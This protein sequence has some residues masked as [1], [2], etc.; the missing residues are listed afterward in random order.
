VDVTTAEP[1]A[2]AEGLAEALGWS[3][4]PLDTV[5]GI[6]R[7]G[8]SDEYLDVAGLRGAT[9]EEDLRGRDFTINAMAIRLPEGDGQAEFLDPT[10]GVDDL[11]A[12][13]LRMASPTAFRDDPVRVMRGFR[14][15]AT[16]GHT[17]EPATLTALQ[18][19]VPRLTRPAPERIQAEWRHVCASSRAYTVVRDMD[20]A[21]ALDVLFPE[22]Q[23]C[24]GVTQNAYHAYDVFEHQ[25]HALE[26]M[27]ALL[28]DP[29]GVLG[30]VADRLL[31]DPDDEFVRGRLCFAALVHDIGKP[32]ARTRDA[33]GVHFHGHELKGAEM[34]RTI[35]ERMRVLLLIRVPMVEAIRNH[36]RPTQLLRAGASPRAMLKFVEATRGMMEDVLLLALADKSA[37]P[38]PA[39]D[40]EIVPKLVALSATLLDFRAEQYVPAI[41]HPLLTGDDLLAA[42]IPQGPRVG[43]LLAEVRR[44][45]VLGELRTREQAER[46][47]GRMRNAE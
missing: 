45:Q 46:W 47:M 22:L 39:A 30:E 38:G 10:G 28:N 37:G 36:M 32:A 15:R 24:K 44:L 2:F 23:A 5:R 34:A 43:E 33:K 29:A 42:G 17:I 31:P 8:W 4:V 20:A 41:L 27:V 16:R 18:A 9:I 19:A 7:V 3:L 40:P 14:L 35:C 12:G 13:V 6:Y 1:L 11:A 21:G 25:M 26:A